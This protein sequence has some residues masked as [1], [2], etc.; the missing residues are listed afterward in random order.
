VRAVPETVPETPTEASDADP[1]RRKRRRR[2]IAAGVVLLLGVVLAA[3]FWPVDEKVPDYVTHPA[4]GPTPTGPVAPAAGTSTPPTPTSTPTLPAAPTTPFKIPSPPPVA[5][6]VPTP[7]TL[8]ASTQLIDFGQS[9]STSTLRLT[10][11]GGQTITVSLTPSAGWLH[12]SPANQL[13][14]PGKSVVVTVNVDRSDVPEGV[15]R[16]AVVMVSDRGTENVN[17]SIRAEHPPQVGRPRVAD[18]APCAPV[19]SATVLDENAVVRATL[20]WSG[21]GGSGHAPMNLT[22]GIWTAS[23]STASAGGAISYQVTATDAR[24]NTATGPA[25]H[26][27]VAP[28]TAASPSL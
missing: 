23:A 2:W 5:T 8:S 14:E 13:I 12:A 15:Q 6:V 22:D 19:V 10:N 9:R 11:T 4:F 25:L 28:C 27:K 26:T 18:G 20:A 24:G 17:V 16:A 7:G 3:V 21:K 1:A